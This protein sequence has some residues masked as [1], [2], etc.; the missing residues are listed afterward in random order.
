[1]I[2]CVKTDVGWF[3]SFMKNLQIQFKNQ[4][5]MVLVLVPHINEIKNPISSLLFKNKLWYY[6]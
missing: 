6:F 1:M 5:I 3:L 2:K 4:I